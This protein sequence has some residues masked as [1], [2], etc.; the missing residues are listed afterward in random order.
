MMKKRKHFTGRKYPKN[1]VVTMNEARKSEAI[2]AA[3]ARLAPRQYA[4]GI[5]QHPLTKL[6]QVWLSMNGL[7][8]TCLSAH[9]DAKLA[10]ADLQEVKALIQSGDLYDDEKTNVLKG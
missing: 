10:K 2:S 7:D 8:V 9:H 5:I 6:Y 1:K 4:A 3:D